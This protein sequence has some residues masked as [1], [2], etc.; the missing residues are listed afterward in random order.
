MW[1]CLDKIIDPR[2]LGIGL[3]RTALGQ[4]HPLSNFGAKDRLAVSPL[5]N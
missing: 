1:V 5:K 4:Q 2:A 3:G